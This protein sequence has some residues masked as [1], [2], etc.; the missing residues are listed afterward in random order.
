MIAEIPPIEETAYARY[1]EDRGEKRGE[2]REKKRGL[3]DQL[4]LIDNF[5]E[6]GK[7]TEDEYVALTTPLKAKLAALSPKTDKD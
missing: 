4:A 2:K 1:F 6:Q 5:Y 7:L 3:M